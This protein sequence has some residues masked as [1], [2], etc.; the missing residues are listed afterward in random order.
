MAQKCPIYTIL[1]FWAWQ[2]FFNALKKVY[3]GIENATFTPIST[4]QGFPLQNKKSI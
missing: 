3:L 1:P 4:Q 2:E